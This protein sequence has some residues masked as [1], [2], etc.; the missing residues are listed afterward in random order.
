NPKNR[1][2]FVNYQPTAGLGERILNANRGA[3]VTINRPVAILA[4]VEKISLS[5]HA[6]SNGLSSYIVR[7][8]PRRG[9]LALVHGH[10]NATSALAARPEVA[11]L[12]PV[13]P[14][15]DDR[16]TARRPPLLRSLWR[17]LVS[18]VRR[19]AALPRPPDL[20][21]PDNMLVFTRTIRP[22]GLALTDD[23]RHDTGKFRAIFAHTDLS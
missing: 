21:A 8:R 6:D 10:P 5:G 22:F 15:N 4:D 23:V 1:I 9:G 2:F 3:T 12:R 18:L 16:L 13:I 19:P 20:R 11:R 14:A 7:T 17:L